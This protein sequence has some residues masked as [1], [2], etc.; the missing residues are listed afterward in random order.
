MSK[1]KKRG[2]KKGFFEVL[3][4]HP[5][6][7]EG[8]KDKTKKLCILAAIISGV[9][10]V[11]LSLIYIILGLICVVSSVVIIGILYIS[12]SARNKRNFCKDC[13]AKFNYEECVSWNVGEVEHKECNTSSN[14]QSKQIKAKDVA[15]VNFTCTCKECGSVMEFSKKYDVVLYYDDG[16][17]KKSNLSNIAKSYFKL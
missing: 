17:F 14:S 9:F 8:A 12:W 7:L 15:T 16:S 5:E 11:L 2:E 1:E 3:K 4:S 13:G 10:V 6:T